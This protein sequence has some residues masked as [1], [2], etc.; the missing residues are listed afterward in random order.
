MLE[1]LGGFKKLAAPKK[2]A[3]FCEICDLNYSDL[4]PHLITPAHVNLV[5][6]KALWAKVDVC[7]DIVN[8]AS[9]DSEK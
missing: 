1:S 3:G 9:D 6:L 8:C 4:Q 7:I 2:Q 5:G